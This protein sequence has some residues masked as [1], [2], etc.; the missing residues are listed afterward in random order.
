MSLQDAI[1]QIAG[2]APK[3]AGHLVRP[4]DW[5]TLIAALGEYDALDHRQH[6]GPGHRQGHL[7]A[8][9]DA[10]GGSGG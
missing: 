10:T 8:G 1:T 5:N 4:Q 9:A 6:A 2:L 7:D 3:S